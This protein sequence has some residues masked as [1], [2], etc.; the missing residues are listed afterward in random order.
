MNQEILDQINMIIPQENILRDEPMSRHT[1]FRT[2][3][4]ADCFIRIKSGE[5]LSKLI[6]LLTKENI[7]FFI[8][9][10]GSN[11]LVSDKGYRGVIISM[12]GLDELTV[13][14]N[15]IHAGAGILTSKVAQEAYKNS[16]T[17]MEALAG[18]PGSIGG[19]LYMN[20][21]AYGSEM[22]DVTVS[23]EIM[24]GDGHIE[25]VSVDDLGLR[26]RGS[27][28]SDEKL[29]VLSVNLS[30]FAGDKKAIEEAMADFAARRRD[31]QPLEFPSAGSTFKRPE[32]YFAGKLIQDAGLR[33][34]SI[35]G[36]QVSEKHCGFVVN[37]G[38]ATSQDVIDVIRHVQKTVLEDSGVKLETEVILLGDF[39]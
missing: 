31:K 27:R 34:F 35:G 8:T 32:G 11:L 30:L 4:P 38:G 6:A 5:E 33:G 36:A 21:G 14:G 22:K 10:N 20:A 24:F 3:G 25:E 37:K 15:R 39:E 16:L 13:D 7:D 17:G 19:C 28:I 26:Y 9:G 12:T 2:G 23:A 1:T 29:L 18:I